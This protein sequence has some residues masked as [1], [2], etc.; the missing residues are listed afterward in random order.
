ML[1]TYKYTVVHFLKSN[2]EISSKYLLVHT[3]HSS[4][5]LPRNEP[6][7]RSV[8]QTGKAELRLTQKC[9]IYLKNPPFLS[10]HYETLSK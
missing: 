3:V 6:Q 7:S 1:Y 5:A 4:L 8:L 10:N 9:A 2:L